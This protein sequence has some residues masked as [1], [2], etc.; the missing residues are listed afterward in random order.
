M[1][2]R[3]KPVLFIFYVMLS[4]AW[5]PTNGSAQVNSG[6]NGS[7]GAFTNANQV[8]TVI[9]MHDHPNGIYQYT[10]VYI[11]NGVT[12]KFIPNANNTPVV[13][14]VQGDV[15]IN[16]A[17]DVSG[18]NGSGNGIGGLG[19]PGGWAGGNGGSNPSSGQGP[20]G[21]IT[22]SNSASI[23]GTFGAIADTGHPGQ[24]YG[25]SFLLPLVGGS[26]AGGCNRGY[27]GGGGG[28][29]ILIAASGSI[30]INGNLIANGG[31]GIPGGGAG[32]ADGSGGGIRLVA[33]NFQGSGNI[34]ASGDVCC[35]DGR[36]G[37]G[38]VRID[39]F[40]FNFGGQITG[41]F[42][43]GYQ[44]IIIPISGQGV[45]LSIASV[46][47]ATVSATPNG[48]LVTPDTIISSQQSNPIPVVVNCSNLPLNTLITVTVKPA[49]GASVS[50]VGYNTTGTLASSTA[51]V[52]LNLPRG[53]GIIYATATNGN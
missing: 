37:L 28:G 18:Q 40:Q 21:G 27:G 12:V 22:I 7:D 17:V 35:S 41:V 20:G 36:G 44:P 33:S 29:A 32:S 25:N 46:A 31:V 13:W 48:Q 42:T 15:V 53:G 16:G 1:N 45:Q 24:I 38:R 10:S 49:N 23:G 6:S 50:A 2:K 11:E 47:G 52:S 4:F 51:T 39:T 34:S 26:G 30:Q 5:N 3:I 8:T 43:Q 14:L 19:G 9:D